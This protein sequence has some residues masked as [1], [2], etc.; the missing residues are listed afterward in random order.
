VANNFERIERGAGGG[1]GCFTGDDGGKAAVKTCAV[2]GA[3][4]TG[5]DNMP[6]G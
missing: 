1:G 2:S 6:L 3:S 5:A 4:S